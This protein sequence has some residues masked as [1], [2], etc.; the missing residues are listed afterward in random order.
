MLNGNPPAG[1][2]I[3]NLKV[4]LVTE[5][6]TQLGG[7][8][9]VLD[10]L[11]EMFPQAP[12]FTL[13]WD[14]A[15]TNHQY[16]HRDIRTTFIQKMPFGVKKYKWYLP[17]M[18]RAIEKINLS[19]YD[20]IISSV[21][22][23]IKG[24]KTYKNQIHLCYCHTPTRYLWMESKSYIKNA[25]IPFFVRPLMPLVLYFLRRWDLKASKR[26]DFYL[27]NSVNVQARIK[28]YYH[29]DSMVLYPPVE[30]DKFKI[31]P[32]IGDYYLLVSRLEPYKKVDMVLDAFNQ[33]GK[34][35][36]IVGGGTKK[37]E[38]KKKAKENIELIGRVD[39]KRLSE[40]YAKAIAF[41]FPQEEDFGITAVES[42]A[43]GRP[44]IAYQKGGA[45]ETVIE[46]KTGVFFAP[47]TANAL[48]DTIRH[49]RP[50]KFNSGAIRTHAQKFDKAIFKA[51]LLA[52]IKSVIKK[53]G[54]RWN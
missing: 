1:G 10:A 26:P 45:L 2:Q 51:K 27:A 35:L 38:L 37:D 44:V 42:M 52:Y 7:A 15:K 28:K 12:I 24:V 39:D 19:E 5:E 50:E 40:F 3:S 4:A 54:I 6:L 11:V 18:P 46:G 17:L 16:D 48:V 41:I 9:R 30:T 31:D 29:R 47:Q 33:L 22:A 20:I 36:K 23:L 43:A 32:K 25:P 21:S 49:F 8:E 13:V 53:K 34:K 14:K